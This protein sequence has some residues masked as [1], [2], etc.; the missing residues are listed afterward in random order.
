[1][2]QCNNESQ[3]GYFLPQAGAD[4]KQGIYFLALGTKGTVGTEGTEGIQETVG[5]EGTVHGLVVAI[6]TCP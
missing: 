5:T 4:E 3:G 1:M 2:C 6:D